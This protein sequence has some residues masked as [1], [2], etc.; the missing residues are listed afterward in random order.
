MKNVTAGFPLLSQNLHAC[1]DRVVL[2]PVLNLIFESV[3]GSGVVCGGG[4]AFLK[5][6]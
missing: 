6:T 1:Q 4:G 3:E 5:L 2:T